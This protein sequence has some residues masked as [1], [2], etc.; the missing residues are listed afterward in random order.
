MKRLII[1]LYLIF[2]VFTINAQHSNSFNYQGVLRDNSGTVI[3]NRDIS[4]RISLLQ[5]SANGTVIYSEIQDTKTNNQGLFS[6]K[7]GTGYTET[8]NFSE[9]SWSEYD[10]FLQIEMDSEGG[11]DYNFIGTSQIVSV[12]Y[13]IQSQKAL[14]ADYSKTSNISDTSL[15]ARSLDKDVLYFPDSDTLFAVKDHEGNIVFAVF[16]DGAKVY[17][18]NNSK[19][20]IGGFAV[21]GRN[22]DKATIEEE[23][24]VV[25]PDSTRVYI[26]ETS[27][28]G[29][30][31]GFAVTGRNPD[32]STD[33]QYL[34]VTADSTR[35][36]TKNAESGFS[37]GNIN[38][39]LSDNYLKLTKDNY[40]IGHEAGKNSTTPGRNLL[41]GY[42]SGYFNDYGDYNVFLGYQ[43]GYNNVSG[44]LNNIIG[45]QSAFSNKTGDYNNIIGFKAA[46]NDTNPQRNVILG[47]EAA[48]NTESNY[49]SI[50][51]GAQAGRTNRIN[52]SS[53]AI[54]TSA[55]EQTDRLLH[56]VLIGEYAGGSCDT[57]E[58]D[59]F[60][61][62]QAGLNIQNSYAN[63]FVGKGAGRG[64]THGG[65]NVL[66]GG[67]T[68]FNFSGAYG[69]NNTVIGYQAGAALQ[70]DGNVFIGYNA[71]YNE[72]GSNKLYISNTYTSNPLIKGDFETGK[73]TFNSMINL[74]GVPE[75][76]SNPEEGDIIRLKNHATDHDGI[77]V[78]TGS[79]WKTITTW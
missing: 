11:S 67:L 54:G 45:Y 59:V 28:K 56:S 39:G 53:V 12:P 15:V 42:Q 49:S 50:I 27:T 26:E 33:Y 2:I 14:T 22:P 73:T 55:A 78:Y 18:N 38:S 7:I 6:L 20:R 75:Y 62:D 66:V 35:I 21:T 37:V 29:R 9:I 1:Q 71:G 30:I 79:T 4:L 63:V 40:F 41:I 32:K 16:P 36:L 58:N 17:V 23:Y 76:P 5:G 70:G 74:T 65:Y 25:T 61:G 8:G 77:Y 10:Y 48:M 68:A 44:R 43:T 51:I 13:A 19:G 69:S 46:F 24:L 64:M 3:S 31:G 60:I 34:K 57:T 52:S 72:T 47:F